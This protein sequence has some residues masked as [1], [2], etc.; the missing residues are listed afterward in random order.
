ML[1]LPVNTQIFSASVTVTTCLEAS[2]SR[3]GKEVH[4]ELITTQCA[5]RTLS[6]IATAKQAPALAV[7]QAL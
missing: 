1:R 6:S 2:S 7:K 5:D 4:T 3:T